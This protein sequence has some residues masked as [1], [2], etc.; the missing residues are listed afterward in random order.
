VAVPGAPRPSTLSGMHADNG[1]GSLAGRVLVVE[2]DADLREVMTGALTGDGHDVV[3]A[4]DGDAALDALAR[5]RFD[6]VLLDIGLGIGPDGVEVCRRLRRAGDDA[7]VLALTARD[8]EADVV[9]ALEAGADDYVTKPVGIAELRSRVRAVLRRVHRDGAPRA[10]IEQAGLRVDADARRAQVD[11]TE[12]ALTYSE[13]EVLAALLRAQGRLLSR[14]QLLDA[15][16]GGHEFRD[17][18]AIDVHVH[19]LREK[20]AAAGGDPDMIVTV[21]SAG[22]RVGG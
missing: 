14:Q 4:A 1:H 12:V 16:F 18:R 13:F 22:Y 20:L 17:P 19:H 8:G 2:D 10:V 6:L 7:H 5:Q 3:E 21:R 15:I 9:L 11:G